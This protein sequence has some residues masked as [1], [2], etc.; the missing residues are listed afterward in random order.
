MTLL[1]KRLL[2]LKDHVCRLWSRTADARALPYKG[3]LLWLGDL[4]FLLFDLLFVPELYILT[5]WTIRRPLRPLTSDEEQL[6]R[7]YFGNAIDL[8][9]VR[10]FEGLSG[11]ITK[12]ALAYVS[13]NI[14]NYREQLP[15]AVFVHELVHVW[16]YQQY[17]SPYILRALLAQVSKAGY[18]YGGVEALYAG[19]MAG[20]LFTSF[21]FE[22]QGEIFEDAY[23][24]SNGV[25]GLNDTMYT[26]IYRYY[27]AQVYQE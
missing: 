12:K 16:Q 5:L 27:T 22:Q 24:I 13:F 3:L 10:I 17:G 4:V 11:Y 2:R 1:T 6:A 21:N 8:G 15:R 26:A 9:K 7:R 20:K 18:D 19:M 25:V 23:K 14:I